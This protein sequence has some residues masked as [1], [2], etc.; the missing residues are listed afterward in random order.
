MGYNVDP[1]V[2]GGSVR[3]HWIAATASGTPVTSLRAW[4]SSWWIRRVAPGPSRAADT[5]YLAT[6]LGADYVN[7]AQIFGTGSFYA[8]EQNPGAFGPL[9][10]FQAQLVPNNSLER[11]FTDV[12][13]SL[14]FD[15]RLIP[16]G[17]DSAAVLHGPIPMRSIGAT[18]VP[19]WD[20]RNFIPL[21][22]PDDYDLVIFS[23]SSTP[24][25][26]LP[27]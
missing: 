5:T 10:V 23:R 16:Q 24:S 2:Y 17:D 4:S 22:L 7:V 19:G 11:V 12:G 15:A 18:F 8:V 13:H 14:L 21:L 1:L 6:A 25:T 9:K 20:E 3:P 26:L 27:P